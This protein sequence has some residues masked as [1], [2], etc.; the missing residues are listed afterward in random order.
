MGHPLA[1]KINWMTHNGWPTVNAPSPWLSHAAHK[2]DQNQWMGHPLILKIGWM[3]CS[4]CPKSRYLIWLVK[5]T[6]RTNGTSFSL[7][8]WLDDPLLNQSH[9]ISPSS[10]SYYLMSIPASQAP[11]TLPTSWSLP[12]THTLALA[13]NLFTGPVSI[14]TYG[15]LMLLSNL[16]FPSHW[17]IIWW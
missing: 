12:Y 13:P 17:S 7:K 14:P 9:Q 11:S 4:G 15:S 8:N 5:L 3:S 2:I 16:H 1:L 10:I 6:E